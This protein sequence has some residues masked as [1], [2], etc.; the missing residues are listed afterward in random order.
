MS[1]LELKIPPVAVLLVAAIGLYFTPFVGQYSAIIG[2]HTELVSRVVFALA[3]VLG[4][5]SILSFKKA[6][7]TVNPLQIGNASNLVTHGIFQ[8]T[9]NPMYLSMALVI[10]AMSI[11]IDNVIALIWII[12]YCAYITHFQIKPEERMLLSLFGQAYADYVKSVR[13]WL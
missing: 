4:V 2:E 1:S 3:I 9:R 5:L 13:R 12:P 10:A 11:R 8:L 7:T 6:K